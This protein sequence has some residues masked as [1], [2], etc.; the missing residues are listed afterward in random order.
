MDR[1]YTVK[2]NYKVRIIIL[3]YVFFIYL[4]TTSQE[5][6]NYIEISSVVKY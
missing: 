3:I 4:F 2:H 1:Y 5:I 6:I